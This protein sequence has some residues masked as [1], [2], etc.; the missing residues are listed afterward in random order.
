MGLVSGV[1]P[2]VGRLDWLVEVGSDGSFRLSGGSSVAGGGAEPIPD[3]A[4]WMV[5]PFETALSVL[6]ISPSLLGVN[7]TL[8]VQDPSRSVLPSSQR[9]GPV[10]Q[11]S[12]RPMLYGP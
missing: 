3:S 9:Q 1:V 4:T 12:K 7:C 5:P 8:T 11:R 6:S 10:R 2:C